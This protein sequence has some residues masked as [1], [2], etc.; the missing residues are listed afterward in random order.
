MEFDDLVDDPYRCCEVCDIRYH[1][2]YGGT[3]VNCDIWI[4]NNCLGEHNQ[5]H[6]RL[7]NLE[8]DEAYERAA[9]RARLNN[10]EETGGKDWT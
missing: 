5:D 1:E 10:F 4:C 2:E 6:N 7:D 8:V 3:C 9:S